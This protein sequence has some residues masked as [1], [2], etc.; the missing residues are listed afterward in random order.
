MDIE[1]VTEEFVRLVLDGKLEQAR[2]FVLKESEGRENEL[3]DWMPHH[4]ADD[5]YVQPHRRRHS[6]QGGDN[7]AKIATP[8]TAKGKA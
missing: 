7:S 4:D 2:E 3:A 5:N 1:E 6:P 8:H